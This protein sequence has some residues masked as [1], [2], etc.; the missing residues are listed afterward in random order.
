MVEQVSLMKWLEG[1]LPAP[2]VIA[3]EEWNGKSFLL[4]LKNEGKII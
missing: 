4:M 3:Y 2:K 1:K